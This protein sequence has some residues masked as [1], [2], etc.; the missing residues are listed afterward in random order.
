MN[1]MR[2]RYNSCLQSSSLV[3]FI[4]LSGKRSI[5]VQSSRS[6]DF[7]PNKAFDVSLYIQS[8]LVCFRNSTQNCSFSV[9]RTTGTV[10]CL[11]MF[12]WIVLGSADDR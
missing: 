5:S 6:I 1:L 11:E 7:I 4:C 3:N 9:R 8:A 10:L 2:G 12:G